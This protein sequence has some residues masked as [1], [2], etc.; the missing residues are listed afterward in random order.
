MR[1]PCTSRHGRRRPH[2]RPARPVTYAVASRRKASWSAVAASRL[3]Y[4][5]PSTETTGIT[6]R[7]DD[8][9]KASS[10]WS[11]SSGN[12]PVSTS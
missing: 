6:S 9:V 2:S 3:S 7:T 10:A 8:D 11:R 4:P 12:A 1:P 5:C